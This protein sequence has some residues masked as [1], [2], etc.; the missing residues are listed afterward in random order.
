[1]RLL[2]WFTRYKCEI[3]HLLTSSVHKTTGRAR[4]SLLSGLESVSTYTDKVSHEYPGD[5]L[6][7]EWLWGI[8]VAAVECV[9]E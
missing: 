9:V 1:M 8:S 3:D 7:E 4:V 5:V 6:S 2:H